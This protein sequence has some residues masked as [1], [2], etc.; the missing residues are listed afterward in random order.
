MKRTPQT[1]TRIPAALTILAALAAP[2]AT[3]AAGSSDRQFAQAPETSEIAHIR[4]IQ[5][6][7][8]AHGYSAGQVDGKAG[9]RTR[10]AIRAYQKAAGLTVD[11]R[12]TQRLLDHLKF[13]LPKVYRFGEPVMGHVLDVQRE[14]AERGYY[15]GPHDGIV[16]PATRR[17]VSSFQRDARLA[18]DPT[19][20]AR[21]LQRIRNADPGIKADS[22]F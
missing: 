5:R 17:A 6:E 7:L 16:G 3:M 11:G 20:D 1:T 8:L 2:P 12:P 18:Q 19:I 4:G 14:L 9:P 22:S 13:A 10:T 15:L 21:L